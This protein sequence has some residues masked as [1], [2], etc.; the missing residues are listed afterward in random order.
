MAEQSPQALFIFLILRKYNPF[1]GH[2]KTNKQT[3]K[4]KQQKKKKTK[5]ETKAYKQPKICLPIVT[6]TVNI[7]KISKIM[8]YIYKQR[9]QEWECGL[10]V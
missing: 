8:Q 9:S 2:S 3:N 4:N 5:T 6:E 10:T 1:C 7:L